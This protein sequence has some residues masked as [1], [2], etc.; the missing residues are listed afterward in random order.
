M[1]TAH[2]MPLASY[3]EHSP[4]EMIRRAESFRAEMQRRRSVRRFSARPVPRQ[5]IE[6]CLLA[7]G[8]APSGAN[9]Q[10][11]QFVVVS[12]PAVK[13]QIRERAEEQEREF[14]RRQSTKEWRDD[15]LPLGTDAHK[16]F[17]ETAPY[18]I[19][20]FS[21][22]Y[23]IVAD[24]SHVSN[25]YVTESVGIATGILLT[26][27][28]HAGLVALTYTPSRMG[29]LN[30]ILGRPHNER[31]FLILV[32]GYPAED[33]QVPDLDRKPLQDIVTFV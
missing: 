24:G 20:V 22:R 14:Y 19:V 9:L 10:P 21:Q 12:D 6:E 8:S 26:A 13:H 25:Y 11:W 30:R 5:V 23:R 32:V 15:L 31:P 7:A 16:P 17:L 29:F 28:H 27:I 3:D 1:T 33:A 4:E 2:M 18:L